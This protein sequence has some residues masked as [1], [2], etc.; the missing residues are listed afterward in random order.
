[1]FR[2]NTIVKLSSTNYANH[3]YWPNLS[4]RPYT[5]WLYGVSNHTSTIFSPSW[6]INFRNDWKVNSIH[7]FDSCWSNPKTL[8][9]L[10][11]FVSY[12]LHTDDINKQ[13]SNKM[14]CYQDSIISLPS[15]FNTSE[16]K[17]WENHVCVW[18]EDKI[19]TDIIL[20]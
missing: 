9:S 20:I 12:K 18:S 8:P 4:T 1:M 14:K 15:I 3:I 5:A 7:I 2:R 10:Q 11:K 16:I 19:C 6:R 17:L 13:I